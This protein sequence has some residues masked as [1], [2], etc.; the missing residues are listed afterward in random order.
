[1]KEKIPVNLENG[2]T[3]SYNA[4]KRNF[5]AYIGSGLLIFFA[6]VFTYMV[7]KVHKNEEEI[8]RLDKQDAV[9]ETKLDTIQK[10]TERIERKWR[11]DHCLNSLQESSGECLGKCCNICGR[12]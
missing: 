8:Y 4:F 7:G 9:I 5:Y 3:K 11:H 6:M 10:S 12:R 1:M 2:N